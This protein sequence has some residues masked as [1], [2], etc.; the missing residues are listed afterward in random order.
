MIAGEVDWNEELG[1]KNDAA[2]SDL[3]AV[4]FSAHAE[5]LGSFY[6]QFGHAGNGGSPTGSTV[7]A[8]DLSWLKGNHNLRFGTEFRW[9]YHNDWASQ[10]NGNYTFPQ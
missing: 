2:G 6:G 3:S 9:Y 1:L 4:V 10:Q 5:V 7:I 8:D